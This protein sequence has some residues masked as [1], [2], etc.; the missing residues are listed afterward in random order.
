[1][2]IKMRLDTDGLRALIKDNPELEVEIGQEVL[3]N[4]KAD[5]IQ[6][7]V[8]AQID[9]C[10]KGMVKNEGSYYT[11]RYVPVD[12]AFK[13]LICQVT[14]EAIG[15]Y[16]TETLQATITEL[17]SV[18]HRRERDKIGNNLKD[19]L[20]DLVTPEMAREIIREKIL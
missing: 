11:P 5:V 10:L 17:A 12:K 9:A 2:T 7:K 4:I 6:N 19:L 20:K 15:H 14:V 16:T 8:N 18:A 1:M 13:E 3:N